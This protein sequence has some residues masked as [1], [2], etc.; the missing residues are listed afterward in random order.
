[1]SV[2]RIGKNGA[3][4]PVPTGTGAVGSAPVGE[5]FSVGVGVGVGGAGGSA[6]AAAGAGPV[7]NVGSKALEQLRGG[8]IDMGQYLDLKVEEATAHLAGLPGAELEAIRGA[9]RERLATDPGL[10]ELVQ[11][12]RL[13]GGAGGGPSSSS[14]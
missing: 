8:A 5:A 6:G 4:A 13:A 12:V 14:A 11:T 1:M 2:D 10:V 3:P 7:A 9:L